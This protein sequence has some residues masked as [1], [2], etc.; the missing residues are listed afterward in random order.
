MPVMTN[1][2]GLIPAMAVPFRPDHSIDEPELMRFA[3]RTGQPRPID[4]GCPQGHETTHA[5]SDDDRRAPDPRVSGVADELV[6]L[7]P[8][9]D[10]GAG[11]ARDPDQRD[12]V[13]RDRV[14]ALEG[15]LRLRDGGFQRARISNPRGP[16]GRLEEAT[17]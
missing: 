2:H 10:R 8:Q 12:V 1:F 17:M 3:R 6:P 11:V 9:P 5:V 4:A 7:D 14:D 13:E 15:G 16:A